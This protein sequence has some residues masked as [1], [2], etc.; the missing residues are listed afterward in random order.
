MRSMLSRRL[1]LLSSFAALLSIAGCADPSAPE[2]V[3]E[4]QGALVPGLQN[5]WTLDEA[6]G[7]TAFDTA[8][9]VDGS[10]GSDVTRIPG[11]VGSGALHLPGYNAPNNYTQSSLYLGPSVGQFGT[12]DF[13]ATYWIRTSAGAHKELLSNRQDGSAENYFDMRLEYSGITVEM[14]EDSGGSNPTVAFVPGSYNDGQ[15]HFVAIS[16]SG[17]SATLW[18]DGQ[19]SNVTAGP[20]NVANG[21]ALEFGN[22]P[23]A[24][25]YGMRYEGD[26]DDI[27]IYD[28]GLSCAE[29]F[30]VRGVAV[31][32]PDG[33]G[34]DSCSNDNCPNV[35]NPGQ[36]DA[37]GDGVGDACDNCP[38]IANANQQD[39]DGDG[40]GDA[41]DNCPNTPNANQLDA[42]NDGFGDACQPVCVTLSP[43][44]DTQIRDD[45]P[46]ANFG[47]K[48]TM[49]VG[50]SVPAGVLRLA[51]IQFDLS[52]I[53]AG[54]QAIS[55]NLNVYNQ[56]NIGSGNVIVGPLFG[57]AW[58]ES[59]MTAATFFGTYNGFPVNGFSNA[60][61]AQSVDITLA[62]NAWLSGEL[63]NVG[64][65]LFSENGADTTIGTKENSLA[66]RRP[67]L[68]LCYSP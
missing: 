25:I 37:D 19:S 66:A 42:D 49:V 57:P 62:A 60:T 8:G 65:F 14:Y 36:Q 68:D 48:P 45:Q 28:H 10:I 41:C 13:S 54:V 17:T 18:V 12:N 67:T 55:A 64:L 35:A 6:S 47:S 20:T 51:L 21:I 4:A 44:D 40:V 38:N 9:G 29:V 53:P 59:T 23:I 30:E 56:L 15:W 43:S 1:Q 24:D 50:N 31:A 3:D 58:T 27:R 22:N 11:V 33:D 46:N 26:V 63:P 34:I 52:A 32:D 61:G 5:Q 7:S 39:A 16:R 2:V